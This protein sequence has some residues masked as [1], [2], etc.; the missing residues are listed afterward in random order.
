[1]NQKIRF[2]FFGAILTIGPLVMD[3]YLSAIPSI[4]KK[5]EYLNH[6]C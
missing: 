2:F 1:V 5:W 4:E 3:A 6:F